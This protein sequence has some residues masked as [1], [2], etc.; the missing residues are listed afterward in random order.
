MRREYRLS[1]I[2]LSAARSD[3]SHHQ[4][5]YRA[6]KLYLAPP[7]Q[8]AC[9]R[10]RFQASRSALAPPDQISCQVIESHRFVFDAVFNEADS[11][12]NIYAG[13]CA[14]RI[15]A[16]SFALCHARRLPWLARNYVY[17]RCACIFACIACT[18]ACIA[19]HLHARVRSLQAKVYL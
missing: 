3:D 6:T 5:R 17:A 14:L 11:N 13:G 16:F 12:E 10:I 7:D 8:I 4:I 15:I 19:S 18:S 2:Y 9:H 1:A